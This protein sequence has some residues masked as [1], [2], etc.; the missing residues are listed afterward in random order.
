VVEL[1]HRLLVRNA[2]Y[3]N[4]VRVATEILLLKARTGQ[5]PRVL[6]SGLPK[7]LYANRGFEYERTEKGFVPSASTRT[8]SAE[9]QSG[10][11]NSEP[12]T[13]S[14]DCLANATM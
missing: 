9:S 6:P 2:V 13:A 4:L 5:L 10:N 12:R 14:R 3:D 7:D 1:Y 8:T 11:S